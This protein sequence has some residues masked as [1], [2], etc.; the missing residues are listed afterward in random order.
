MKRMYHIERT[1]VCATRG[2]RFVFCWWVAVVTLHLVD[3]TASP[4]ATDVH[5]SFSELSGFFFLHKCLARP[6]PLLTTAPRAVLPFCP[7]RSQTYASA[8]PRAMTRI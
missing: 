6:T 4:A 7:V 2:G 1:R 5:A 8:G 3:C